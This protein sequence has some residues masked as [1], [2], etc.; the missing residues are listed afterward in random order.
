MYKKQELNHGI[1]LSLLCAYDCYLDA[2]FN[3]VNKKYAS[4]YILT[5]IAREEIGKARIL[6]KKSDA[7]R[8]SD[9]ISKGDI[10]SI[11]K[12]HKE[13]IKSSLGVI[14]VPIPKSLLEKLRKAHEANDSKMVKAASK[15]LSA[16]SKKKRDELPNELHDKRLSAQ[17]VNAIGNGKWNSR[18]CIKSEDCYQ[19]LIHVGSEIFTDIEWAFDQ[20]DCKQELEKRAINRNNVWE[21]YTKWFMEIVAAYNQDA[22]RLTSGCTGAAEAAR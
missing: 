21:M 10:D 19:E 15:E 3:F 9:A 4:S 1:A 17:Y 16:L 8:E 2:V 5:I 14:S 6:K 13:K 18:A 20:S 22:N 7:M 11:I 12:V